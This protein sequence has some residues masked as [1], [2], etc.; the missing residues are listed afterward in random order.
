MDF[1]TP[2]IVIGALR[3]GSGKTTLAIGLLAAWQGSGLAVAPFK[4]GPDFID[5]GWLAFAAGRNCYNLD[6]FLMDENQIL[7]SLAR[8]SQGA[9]LALIEGNR[10]LF[11]GLDLEGRYSTAQLARTLQSPVLLLVDVTMV[12]R[13]AAAL[14]R[15]CQVFDPDLRLAAVVLNRV[16][17]QR[18]ESLV[19]RA[20]ETYCGI[21]VV[22]AIRRLKQEIFPERH[23]GLIPHQERAH[24]LKAVDRARRVILDSLQLEDIRRIAERAPGIA[25]AGPLQ[26]A[27]PED[28]RPEAPPAPRIGFIRD[29]AFWF[30][31]PE[32]LELL[33]AL[34]AE[35]VEVNALADRNLPPLDA[36]YIGGGF[37]ETQARPLADN[38]PFRESLRSAIEEGLP[39]YAECGGLMYLGKHLVIGEETF[40][41]LG[42]FAGGLRAS[43]A[44]PGTRLHHPGGAGFQSL[45]PAR[46]NDQGPR[47]PLFP[48]GFHGC[49]PSGFRLPG[50][51][52]LGNRRPTGRALPQERAG[53]LQPPARGRPPPLGP[54][55]VPAGPGPARGPEL[56]SKERLTCPAFCS[57]ALSL[58]RQA[59][60]ICI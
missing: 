47:V 14:V 5:S 46:R 35:L 22:G 31:Y 51:A 58:D 44:A 55:P 59:L 6:P 7:G 3:G 53:H 11:D 37:P 20:I 17:G 10:G 15:G 48:G 54:Q 33:Q 18:Q 38:A 36:L 12:T 34:G 42:V 41:M 60:G 49:G 4:K 50:A 30:Y 21:P 24:A 45:F 32:N 1:H 27:G 29:R 19:R 2:R 40:P 43:A 9:E 25:W 16:A 26:A 8:H 13:T 52:R 57:I 28:V 56:F 23:M 39:V